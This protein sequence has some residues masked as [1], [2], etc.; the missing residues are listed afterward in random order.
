MHAASITFLIN[1]HN[2]VALPDVAQRAVTRHCTYTY[3]R[4]ITRRELQKASKLAIQT[5]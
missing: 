1:L 2:Y 3:I 4:H 5:I